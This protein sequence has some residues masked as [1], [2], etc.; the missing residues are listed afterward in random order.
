MPLVSLRGYA[1]LRNVSPTAVHK[2]IK[3]GQL[4]N[5]ISGTGRSLQINS[6]IADQE[7]PVLYMCIKRIKTPSLRKS[8]SAP[9]SGHA[10][11]N[12]DY[13][14]YVKARTMRMEYEAKLMK[15]KFEVET[16]KLV[17]IEEVKNSWVNI[18]T[19]ARTK[20]LAVPVKMKQR[21]S[22]FSNEHYL[23]LDEILRETLEGIADQKV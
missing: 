19:Q 22:D 12:Q 14:R 17:S 18:A 9:D 10:K 20:I 6:D 13:D 7:W 5:A 11:E 1:R 8:S 15:L 3:R 16:G 2:A 21:I 23:I 4:R